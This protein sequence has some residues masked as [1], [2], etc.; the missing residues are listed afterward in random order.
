MKKVKF[1][2]S[3]ITLVSFVVSCEMSDINPETTGASIEGTYVGT[4][5][6][7]N[8]LKGTTLSNNEGH[9]A[10]AEVKDMG[11]GE[12]QVHCYGEEMDTTFMLNYYENHDS[13]MVCM[14]GEAFEEMYGHEMGCG[15]NESEM[16]GSGSGGGMMG[17][18]GGMMGGNTEGMMNGN[19]NWTDHMNNEH[20]EGDEHF[21]GFDM[22]TNSFEYIIRKEDITYRFNGFRK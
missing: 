19:A 7:V 15:T 12:I 11:N 22:N 17:S 16:M 2:I 10:V 4:L 20:S 3:L 6:N 13:V 21:G 9:D 1:A 8:S 14:N 18:G 5:T